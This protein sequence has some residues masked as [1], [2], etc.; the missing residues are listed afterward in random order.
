MKS[1]IVHHLRKLTRLDKKGH[2]DEYE[3]MITPQEHQ[4]VTGCSQCGSKFHSSSPVGTCPND[5]NHEHHE[6]KSGS[7]L[8][9]EGDLSNKELTR[10]QELPAGDPEHISPCT[11]IMPNGF[12]VPNWQFLPTCQLLVGEIVFD[13]KP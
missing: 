5:A 11:M 10:R 12:R 7:G 13:K 2:M 4:L 8:L 3:F 6:A 1:K 9:V